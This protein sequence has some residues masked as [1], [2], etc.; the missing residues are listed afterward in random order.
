[1]R[2][3]NRQRLKFW[4]PDGGL[5][6]RAGVESDEANHKVL[7][8]VVKTAGHPG[9]SL[10]LPGLRRRLWWLLAFVCLVGAGP[11]RPAETGG[12]ACVREDERVIVYPG[13]GWQSPGS[14]TW[15]VEVAGLVCEPESRRFLRKT[16]AWLLG[17]KTDHLTAAERATLEARL[18]LFMVDDQS[19]RQPVVWAG[20]NGPWQP[21]TASDGRFTIQATLSNTPNPTLSV[22]AVQPSDGA[23]LAIGTVFLLPPQGW[24][25]ISDLDDT[26]K[27]S[28][29]TN[30]H[31]LMLNTFVRPLVAVPG[32]AAVYTGWQQRAGAAFHYVSASPWQLYPLLEEFRQTN[33]FPAGSFHLKPVRL[34]VGGLPKLW[35]SPAKYKPA[36]IKAL[37]ARYP[38]RQFIL[39]GDSG[40][41][42]PEIYGALAR[43][44][45]SQVRAIY[46]REIRPGVLPNDPRYQAAFQEVPSSRWRVF[47]QPSEI[48]DG[49]F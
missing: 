46:I 40:E 12:R 22:Q 11:A 3:A 32:M 15:Q 42:D 30:H 4:W 47:T 44:H 5:A 16:S 35:T 38:Q 17:I 29:V 41:R 19:G 27:I 26:L 31:E 37:L 24:S 43:Q 33:R 18:G 39:V 49:P 48:A 36:V 9:A 25:V 6:K 28:Q 14:N 23:L 7:M 2:R 1:V 20:D 34:S 13:L 21:K 45:P 10:A 8:C